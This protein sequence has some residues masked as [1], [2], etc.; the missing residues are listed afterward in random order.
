MKDIFQACANLTLLPLGVIKGN[1][2]LRTHNI[3]ASRHLA[4]IEIFEY[5]LFN[6]TEIIAFR[7]GGGDTKKNVKNLFFYKRPIDMTL[8][9]SPPCSES[10]FGAKT[11]LQ[12]ENELIKKLG[13][14][15]SERLFLKNK[16]LT[17]NKSIIGLTIMADFDENAVGC[18]TIELK[19]EKKIAMALFNETN[20]NGFIKMVNKK[21]I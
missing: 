10:T 3:A 2:I 17:G 12:W 14:N 18:G 1:A 16:V 5:P 4:D 8:T 13:S 21:I 9:T 6:E 20:I 15:K 19:G 7:N 11:K